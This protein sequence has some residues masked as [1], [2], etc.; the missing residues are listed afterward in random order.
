MQKKKN[1][2]N[3]QD[4]TKKVTKRVFKKMKVTKFI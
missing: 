1:K 3:I 4:L 2:I